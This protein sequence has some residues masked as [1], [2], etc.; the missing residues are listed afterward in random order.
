MVTIRWS[1][2]ASE[3]FENICEYIEIDSIFYAKLFAEKLLYAIQNLEKFP[4]I[5]RIV[6]E[7]NQTNIRELIYKS[8]RIIYRFNMDYVDILS[9]FHGS[10]I[11][12][13]DFLE[14]L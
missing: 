6:P 14:K 1:L 9:V 2:Q 5:G 7:I 13:Q 8:Y 10:R 3:E 12:N 11:L 4:K